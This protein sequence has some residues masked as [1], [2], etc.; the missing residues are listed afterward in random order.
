[1]TIKCSESRW[2]SY[3]LCVGFGFAVS[4]VPR[5]SHLGDS[6][7]FNC[8]AFTLYT[9][10]SFIITFLLRIAHEMCSICFVFF[11]LSNGQV[12][13]FSMLLNWLKVDITEIWTAYRTSATTTIPAKM[14]N[15]RTEKWRI[16]WSVATRAIRMS[17]TKQLKLKIRTNKMKRNKQPAQR[18]FFLMGHNMW[19]EP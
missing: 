4:M 5:E 1:M 9:I 17:T 8:T 3:H 19:N 11:I 16:I 6:S 10:F 2:T 18:H 13:L 12:Y 15:K 7:G 14:G